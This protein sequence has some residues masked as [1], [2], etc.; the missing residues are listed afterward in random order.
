[1]MNNPNTNSLFELVSALPEIYQPI[2]GY[3]DLSKNVSRRSEDRL[4]HITQIYRLLEEQLKRPLRVLDLGCAQGYFSLS[5]AKLGA[6]VYGIDI[7]P[8][9]IAV[10]QLLSDQHPE[11]NVKFEVGRIE[12]ILDKLKVDD[13][14]LVLGL[15]VFHHLVHQQGLSAVRKIISELSLKVAVGIYELAL[16]EEPLYW[17]PSQPEDPRQLIDG[18]AFVHELA[19]LETHVSTISR[20]L[21]VASNRYWFLDGKVGVFDTWKSDSHR[22]ANGVHQD[23]RRYF[24]GNGLVIKSYRLDN[25]SLYERNIQEY[26]NEISF[27]SNVPSGFIAPH[28]LLYG[29]N[30]NEAWIVRESLPGELL[31]DMIHE[32]KSYNPHRLIRDILFQLVILEQAGLYHNDVRTWNVLVSPDGVA[33]LIDYGAISKE[34]KDCEWPHDPLLSFFIFINEVVSGQVVTKDPLRNLNLNLNSFPEPYRTAM[35]KLLDSKP[36]KWSF[37]YLYQLITNDKTNF[38]VVPKN[39]LLT[40]KAID[41]A[42]KIYSNVINNLREQYAQVENRFQQAESIRKQTETKF[43]RLQHEFDNLKN[44]N[45]ELNHSFLHWQTEVERLNNKL[46]NTQNE[47]DSAKSKIEE[48]NHSS[49]HWWT[50]ANGLNQELQRVYSSRSWR[51]TK[52]LRLL[53]HKGRNLQDFIRV[54][55]NKFKQGINNLIKSILSKAIIFVIARPKLKTRMISLVRKFPMIEARLKQFV[56][57]REL[58]QPIYPPTNETIDLAHL[59]PTARR[60]YK[61]LKTAIEQRKKEGL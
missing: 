16:H 43:H 53:A 50:V 18:Y 47:L 32:G 46:Q 41:E 38:E 57:N 2:F 3:P 14:D 39:Y 60:I 4:V 11:L 42:E 54:I 55:L 35:L 29:Q 23:T 31:I 44:E 8:V 51:I 28:L 9:N 33:S 17:G 58:S 10:C 49:H 59:T 20:P 30:E 48:L 56:R 7:L 22:L 25:D 45:E 26:T 61:E 13:Y 36:D 37:T 27:L 40:L 21:Y 52:P 1:M 5:L 12:E 6:S 34:K 15:S 24:F 19:R